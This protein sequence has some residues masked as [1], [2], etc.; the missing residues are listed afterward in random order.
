[1]LSVIILNT[2]ITMCVC[3][4]AKCPYVQNWIKFLFFSSVLL[5]ILIFC[6]LSHVWVSSNTIYC[7]LFAS[8]AIATCA[9]LFPFVP[10]QPWKMHQF[11]FF[12]PQEKFRTASWFSN[13]T[14]VLNLRKVIF[15]LH[16][17]RANSRDKVCTS[18]LIRLSFHSLLPSNSFFIYSIVYKKKY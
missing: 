8:T 12:F 10:E 9:Q 14:F 15:V 18:T 11:P 2:F 5:Y 1:M 13:S 17:L 6:I 16:Q 7:S 3:V 4:C